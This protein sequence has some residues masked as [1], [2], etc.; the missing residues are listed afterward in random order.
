MN[1]FKRLRPYYFT[2]PHEKKLRDTYACR[3]SQDRK[4]G[5][6]TIAV[7]SPADLLYFGGF[8]EIVTALRQRLP[9]R[10]DRYVYRSLRIGESYFPRGFLWANL[11]ENRWTDRRWA[12]LYSSYCNGVAAR[13]ASWL[14]PLAELRIWRNASRLWRQARSK[15]EFAALTVRGILIGD[16]VIDSYI[17]FKPDAEFNQGDRFTFRILRQALRDIEKAYDYFSKHKPKMFLTSY[18][19][20]VQHGVPARVAIALG[21]KVVAFGN[22]QQMCKTLSVEDVTYMAEHWSYRER[23]KALSAVEQ[24]ARRSG[25]DAKLSGRM[26]GEIDNAIGYMRSS[27]YAP[28][29]T[30]VPDVRGAVI[31]YLPDFYDSIHVHRW[32]AFHDNWEWA[33]ITIDTLTEAG[34]RFL[35]KDHPNASRESKLVRDRLQA[36]YPEARFL[37]EGITSVQL[38]EAGIAA[39]VSPRGT[40]LAELSY[41]GVPVIAAGDHPH[42]EFDLS[43][44]PRTVE[45]YR[46]RLLNVAHLPRDPQAMRDRACEFYAMHNF[47]PELDEIALRDKWLAVRAMTMTHDVV[48]RYTVDTIIASLVELGNLPAFHKYIDEWA[49]HIASQ[50]SS[51][52]RQDQALRPKERLPVS[53]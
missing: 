23:F 37:P 25:A 27:A 7:Q 13:S 26:R 32:T 15:D 22:R 24:R 17:R 46:N 19:T 44:P 11:A 5:A 2:P 50:A 48:A 38:A 8:G 34:M 42:A 14:S 43:E 28:A 18:T 36:R 52:P 10:V 40:V 33:C 51:Q 30:E 6:N 12:R 45:D 3:Q 4:V 41:L 29:S 20:Y 35:I 16:L 39:G 21:I 49:D 31:V 1:F 53:A 47:L 9:L